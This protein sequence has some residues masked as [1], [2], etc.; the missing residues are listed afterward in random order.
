VRTHREIER[1]YSPGPEVGLPDLATVSGVDRVGEPRVDTLEATYF[2]TVELALARAGVSLRRRSGGADEGWHLK[3]PSGDGRDERQLPLGQS[4]RRPPRQL[5][6]AVLGWSRGAPLVA[7]ATIETR[8]TTYQLFGADDRVLA[9]VADDEVHGTRADGETSSWH[10]WEVELVDGDPD[11]L[12]AA[13]TVMESHGVRRSEVERKIARVLGDRVPAP[14]RLRKPKPGKPA[15]RVVQARLAAQ[16]E[17][18]ACRDV[19]ARAGE[20]EGVHKARVACRRLRAALATFRPFLDR[21]VTDPLRDEIR[22]LARSLGEARDATVVHQRLGSLLRSEPRELIAGPVALRLRSTYAGRAGAPAALTDP[23]YYE[24]RAA[25]DRLVAEPPWTEKADRPARDVLPKR[26]RKEWK[27]LRRK[28]AAVEDAEGP[29]ARDEA[30]HDVRKAAKRLRYAAE[31]LEPVCGK[32]AR[33]LARAAKA[34][35]SYLGE[36]QDTV[37]SREELVLLARAALDAGEPTFTYGRMH[38]REEARAVELDRGLANQWRR[39]TAPATRW[40]C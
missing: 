30:L 33:K 29:A 38:A 13:D 19:R 12:D 10:E 21:E 5:G 36:R 40:T 11:L 34:F 27:R 37:S 8:R 20:P 6:D 16:V 26:V 25:L 39:L 17:A 15:T 35:T 18:L 9:E 14:P 28:H 2:D 4:E 23:R 22:W 3:V 7:V 32:D 1:T 24:L 31:A